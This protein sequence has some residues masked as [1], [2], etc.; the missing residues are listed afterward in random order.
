MKIRCKT[1]KLQE[2]KNSEARSRLEKNYR[3]ASL[4]FD[5]EIGQEFIVYGI[6]FS[7]N[8]PEYYILYGPFKNFPVPVPMDFFEVIDDRL[9]KYWSLATV[10]LSQLQ[11][12]NQP[13]VTELVFKEWALEPL[14]YERLIDYEPEELELFKQ[15]KILI[16]NE[17]S[18]SEQNNEIYKFIFCGSKP[19][20]SLEEIAT[21][22]GLRES[23]IIHKV[24]L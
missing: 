21:L 4:E 8:Y 22:K 19:K 10:E 16:D 23:K 7:E 13:P 5:F 11:M 9:S 2:I 18:S 6:C 12:Y 24:K 17:Y 20:K 15:Y 3:S 1:N 14:F